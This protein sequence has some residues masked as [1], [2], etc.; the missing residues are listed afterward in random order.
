VRTFRLASGHLV[1]LATGAGSLDQMSLALPEGVYTTFRTYSDRRALHLDDHVRRLTD[2]A[3]REGYP[4][5]LDHAAVRTALAQALDLAGYALA[6]VRL[7]LT[8][9]PP[10]DLYIS[11]EPFVPLP[12]RLYAAGVDV[13]T[14]PPALRRLNPQAKATRFIAPG[15]AARAEH[16]GANEVLLVGESGEI[17]EGSSSNFFAVLHDTLYTADEGVLGG[18]TRAMVLRLAESM[19]PVA[20]VPVRVG[21]IADLSEAFLTSVSRAVLPVT[22]IDGRAIGDGRPGPITCRLM[23]TF[24]RE[25]ERELAPIAL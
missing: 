8:Y 9:D 23:A 3:R 24:E 5:A 22:R 11:L 15:S 20:R 13:V 21:D 1:D 25:L 16:V 10:G 2:S 17:L 12:A 7:T 18:I 14:G 6:R 4:L 19:L